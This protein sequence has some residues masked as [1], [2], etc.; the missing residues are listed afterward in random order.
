MADYPQR[1]PPTS[2]KPIR[3]APPVPIRLT[4]APTTTTP[5]NAIPL[6]PLASR[7]EELLEYTRQFN[8]PQHTSAQCVSKVDL[9]AKTETSG[10]QV[11]GQAVKTFPTLGPGSAITERPLLESPEEAIQSAQYEEQPKA[12]I[13]AFPTMPPVQVS[14]IE[15]KSNASTRSVFDVTKKDVRDFKATDDPDWDDEEEE[16]LRSPRAKHCRRFVQIVCC[17]SFVLWLWPVNFICLCIALTTSMK[18]TL[19]NDDY[20]NTF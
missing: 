13:T 14:Q 10:A 15:A 9:S 5:S 20:N 17:I 16:A 7:R 3:T 11:S 19:N 2:S 1:P 8:E 18:V 12:K 4:S 6:E